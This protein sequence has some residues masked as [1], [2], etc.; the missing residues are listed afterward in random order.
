M[1]LN[2][3]FRGVNTSTNLATGVKQDVDDLLFLLSPTDT[4]LLTGENYNGLPGALIPLGPP[5]EQTKIE[6]TEF[7]ALVPY[8]T[9]TTTIAAGITTLVVGADHQSKFQIGDLL[10]TK[11]GE[12]LQVTAY[13]ST[14]SL[15]VTRGM[16]STTAAT[17]T[18]GDVIRSQGPMLT[19]GSVPGVSRV[20]DRVLPFNYTRI[21]GPSQLQSTAT[22]QLI[23]R[24]GVPDEWAL[25][26]SQHLLA[27]AI[28]REQGMLSGVRSISSGLRS[29]GG[30]D[31]FIGLSGVTD[32]SSTQI[33]A[34]TLQ[35]NL[36]ATLNNGGVATHLIVNGSA[37][38]T[39]NDLANT[40]VVRQAPDDSM[41]GRQPVQFISTE[42]GDVQ[43]VRDRYCQPKRAYGVILGDGDR[44]CRRIL[45]PQQI[46]DLAK[47]G[48]FDSAMIVGEESLQVK[49]AEH[50][51]RYTNLA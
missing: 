24:W 25:Q 31:F 32:S 43:I 19:E 17:I 49:G 26:L 35:T 37:L 21:Y 41:R 2:N 18:T 12:I 20:A 27:H 33:T 51:F 6:W 46:V 29:A 16:F 8:A 5:A 14:D 1:P 47:T 39:I 36:Q 11:D 22:A 9:S 7:T 13:V 50:M 44:I 48:D 45:R 40:S 23:Q 3:T 4:P 34:T 30:I 42:F 10:S 38:S 15:T 28:Y